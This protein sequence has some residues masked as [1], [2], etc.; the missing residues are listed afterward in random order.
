MNDKVNMY[1]MRQ[2]LKE[3][4]VPQLK[5][6][7]DVHKVFL[8]LTRVAAIE[9]KTIY[10]LYIVKHISPTIQTV[11]EDLIQTYKDDKLYAEHQ[12]LEALNTNRIPGGNPDH[13]GQ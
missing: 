3:K 1:T 12:K 9:R 7:L 4:E 13:S 10:P 11:L 2:E 6:A 5:E 8:F